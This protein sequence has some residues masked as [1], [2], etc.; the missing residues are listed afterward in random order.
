MKKYKVKC[1]FELRSSHRVSEVG[2]QGDS[3]FSLEEGIKSACPL[4][5]PNTEIEI[6]SSNNSVFNVEV[7]SLDL[8]KQADQVSYLR[9][10]AS[11]LSFVTA[12]DEHNG[13][14]GAPY[15]NVILETFNA[16]SCEV[17]KEVLPDNRNVLQ[18]IINPTESV[19][20]N[21]KRRVEFNTQNIELVQYN[22]LLA[23]YYNGLKAESE[24]SKF[25]H[26]FLI[27][28]FLEGSNRYVEMFPSGTMFTSAEQ[29]RIKSL[30]K[31]LSDDG[32]NALLLVLSRTAEFR[33]QKLS[34][35]LSELGITKLSSMT[36]E[37]LVTSDTVKSV[38]AARNKL[39]H[40]GSEFPKNILWA[41]LFPLVTKI[42]EKTIKDQ[43]CLEATSK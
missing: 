7:D 10:L 21:I 34:N 37:Q 38:T 43:S 29:Q 41:F 26:W 2:F 39:F 17:D 6:I 22:E 18:S 24:K 31:T 23:Y 13:H 16:T 1:D 9:K 25:F 19:S 4:G 42:V 35:F 20:I 32:K 15:I 30:A 36:G 40:K 28:E 12:K 5:L 27:I 14:Y 33:N 11:Y 3:S 8:V